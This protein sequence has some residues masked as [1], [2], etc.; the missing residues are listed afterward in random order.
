MKGCIHWMM[1]KDG[2]AYIHSTLSEAA[3]D[4]ACADVLA[5][6]LVH[7]RTRVAVAAL[8]ERSGALLPEAAH[9]GLVLHGRAQAG[10]IL[11]AGCA[12]VLCFGWRPERAPAPVASSGGCRCRRHLTTGPLAAERQNY[13]APL[14]LCQRLGEQLPEKLQVPALRELSGGLLLVRS[15]PVCRRVDPLMVQGGML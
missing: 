11:E 7:M 15:L 12:R 2:R 4:P 10:Q 6:M 3:P 9:V 1:R 13:S 8:A 14:L 5:T